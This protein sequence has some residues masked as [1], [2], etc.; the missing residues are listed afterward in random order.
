M[1]RALAVATDWL[2]RCADTLAGASLL[3]VVLRR[4]SQL[5]ALDA[6]RFPDL[7]AANAPTLRAA[8]IEAWML[9]HAHGS[10]GTSP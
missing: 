7:V 10:A 4:S 2:D 3:G 5:G 1:K 8:L 9:D 6:R